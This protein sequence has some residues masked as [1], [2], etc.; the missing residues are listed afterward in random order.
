MKKSTEQFFSPYPMQIKS[1]K[2]IQQF[3]WKGFQG[4]LLS[5][6]YSPPIGDPEYTEM[7]R[8]LRT[9][10]DRASTTRNGRIFI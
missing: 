4:R 9:I 3:T 6:S 1:Y 8:D 2:N 5:A 10:F 7:M